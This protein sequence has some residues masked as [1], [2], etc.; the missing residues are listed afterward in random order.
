[1]HYWS[2]ALFLAFLGVPEALGI[3][4]LDYRIFGDR[5][6]SAKRLFIYLIPTYINVG[7][8]IYNLFDDGFLFSIDSVEKINQYVRGPGVTISSVILY[9]FLVIV[10]I[11]FFKNKHLITGRI[12]Q[13][14][15]IFFFLPVIGSVLQLL[16]YGTT[17]GMAS[18]TIAGF[19]IFLVLEKD[20]MGKDELTGLYARAK[21]AAR[22]GFKLKA[23]EA[24]SVI[25]ADLNH[26]KSIND[27]YGHSEGD[28]VLKKVADI[29][30]SNVNIEDMVCRYGGDEF[31]V[32]VEYPEDI[33]EKIISRIEKALDKYN[34]SVE[35]EV[36]LSFGYEYIE[37]TT[38][39]SIEELLHRVDRKM[40]EN[41]KQK[42]LQR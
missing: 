29:L 13:S 25:M 40:Y 38:S 3:R 8:A 2:N 7:F 26:F 4:Y 20:E 24:F 39:E 9:A 31:L 19:I 1:M 34:K 37:K 18:Y 41:K 32:L 42:M 5:K 28:K 12:A 14:I 22:L 10:L 36:K 16:A 6:K 11:A 17:F 30:L 15:L 33:S 35:Y 21:L 27:T 23:N